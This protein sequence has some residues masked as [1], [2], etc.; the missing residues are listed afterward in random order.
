LLNDSFSSRTKVRLR[1]AAISAPRLKERY[2]KESKQ[3][4]EKLLLNRMVR[5][6]AFC[7]YI[8]W[9]E[10]WRAAVAYE[11]LD[12]GTEQIKSGLARYDGSTADVQES[13]KCYYE[14]AEKKAQSD[15]IGIW[16]KLAK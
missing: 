12:A 14:L 9:K 2:W 6:T 4:L 10:G 13:R 16:Q 15:R 3:S 8:D 1:L 11:N 7:A 5:I